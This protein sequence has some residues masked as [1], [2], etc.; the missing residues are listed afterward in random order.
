M[1]IV[2]NELHDQTIPVAEDFNFNFR[3]LKTATEAI[4]AL[5]AVL[6]PTPTGAIINFAGATA[7]AG[8]LLCDGAE[9][10]RTTFA[11][12]FA[13]IGTTHGAGDGLTTFNIPNL[14]GRVSVGRDASQAEFATI[15]QAGG[16]KTHTLTQTEMPGHTHGFVNPTYQFGVGTTGA[17]TGSN[18]LAATDLVENRPV[19]ITTGG[20]IGAT[21]GGGAHN[22]LQPYV[23]ENRIIKT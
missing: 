20:T 17:G 21:G 15:G 22:N 16:A 9:V 8:W 18:V 23:V 7:P 19:G 4:E 6:V 13:V 14:K 3:A 5:A 11:A 1:T 12:L 10:S 2:L